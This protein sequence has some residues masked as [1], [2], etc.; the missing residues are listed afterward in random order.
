MAKDWKIKIADFGLSRAMGGTALSTNGEGGTPHWMPPEVLLG[1]GNVTEKSDV[2]SFGV[3]LYEIVTREKPW[4]HL[5]MP[6]QVLFMI[7]KGHR[8]EMPEGVQPEILSLAQDCWQEDPTL[9]PSF[10]TIIE[11]LSKL[12]SIA[13]PQT[14]SSGGNTVISSIPLTSMPSPPLAPTSPAKEAL[15]HQA[16]TSGL[17]GLNPYSVASK[18]DTNP[19]A[20]QQ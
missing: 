12:K 19:F 11:R 14:V 18:P 3:I 16:V 7:F 8:L 6:Q 4:G 17:S 2:F 15:D 9:R 10:A 20:L 13:P 1:S 5:Q